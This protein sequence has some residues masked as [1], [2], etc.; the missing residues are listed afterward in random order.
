MARNQIDVE[1]TV[2][3]VFDVLRDPYSYSDWV[4]GTKE[5]V[6]ADDSWPA[7]GSGFRFRV[8]A[9]P[10]GMRGTTRVLEFDDGR[11]LKLE[12]KSLPL[13]TI[14]ITMEAHDIGEG[15][16]RV[17]LDES[18]SAMP[19]LSSGFDVM[20]H[21]RNYESLTRFRNLVEGRV[22]K[23]RA[24]LSALSPGRHWLEEPGYAEVLA[25]TNS[26][27]LGIETQDGPHVVPV[28]FSYAFGRLWVIAER[29]SL[30]TR[31]A[32]KRSNV[33]VLVRDGT[34]SIVLRGRAEILDVTQPWASGLQIVER[35]LSGPAL[36]NYV[37]QN[38]S[39]LLLSS[40]S[41][42]PSAARDLNPLERVAIVVSPESL[43]LVEDDAIVDR[44]GPGEAWP[45]LDGS[46][47]LDAG[48]PAD[49]EGAEVDLD[50]VPD[51]IA[52]LAEESRAEAALGWSSSSGP[53]V[54]PARWHPERSLVSTPAVLLE[55]VSESPVAMCLEND[56]DSL[57]ELKGFVIRGVGS[58]V[59][60]NGYAAIAIEQEKVT[61]WSG[62]EIRTIT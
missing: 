41:N 54:L 33:G 4:V 24:A 12:T 32:D 26:C 30:K 3:D 19:L 50:A 23:R 21:L 40:I 62:S 59:G 57:D 38:A 25:A 43:C 56:G 2:D 42:A 9:G 1:A 27:F 61:Y 46:T 58:V 36:V 17:T 29:S 49:A 15:R 45:D 55:G 52:G 7:V 20:L 48:S 31:I 11:R 34:S 14:V 13:G 8:G 39:Q 22:S 35:L 16:S 47:E 53:V 5:I 18:S 28:A 37:K 10:V 60:S 6:D 51:S 44:R